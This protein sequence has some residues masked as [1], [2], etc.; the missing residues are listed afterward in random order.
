MIFRDTLRRDFGHDP[1]LLR[2]QVTRTVRHE[3]AHHVGFDE[4][5]VSGSTCSEASRCERSGSTSRMRQPE[6]V[7]REQV[8][9]L[10]YDDFRATTRRRVRA[11][12]ATSSTSTRASP[13]EPV[14]TK[15]L[16]GRALHAPAPACGGA[17]RRRGTEP[18]AGGR[19]AR[20]I[21]ALAPRPLRSDAIAAAL[22]PRRLHAPQRRPTSELM[23]ELR[24]RFKPEVEALERVS[25]SRSGD[26]VG[27]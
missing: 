19:L 12:A 2:D 21:D 27:L 7:P 26:A 14:E 6:H 20:A 4:L 11:G 3:L 22:A 13:I 23:L 17:M 18:A 10:I 15:P 24:R 16:E 25:R 9:V 5:G 1:E 8:L